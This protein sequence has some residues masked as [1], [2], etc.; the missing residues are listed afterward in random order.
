MWVKNGHVAG[1]S[2]N[3][4]DAMNWAS[5]LYYCGY[6]DWRLPASEEL[7]VFAK[8]VGNRKTGFPNVNGFN[9]ISTG[10][11]WSSTTHDNNNGNAWI[12]NISDGSMNNFGKNLNNYVW[13]VRDVK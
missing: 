6:S 7:S 2:M 3:W 12:V 11:Y 1:R 10:G 9:N 4:Q 5:A 13:P 8:R